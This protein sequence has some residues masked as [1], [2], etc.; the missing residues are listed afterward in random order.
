MPTPLLQ[1]IS[2]FEKLVGRSPNYTKLRVFGCLCYPRLKR[3]TTYKLE[4]KSKPCVSLGYSST[5]SAFKCLDPTTK[6]TLH[7]STCTICW[8]YISICFY[9]LKLA[10]NEEN[11]SK[12]APSLNSPSHIS[13]HTSS[14]IVHTENHSPLIQPN[15]HPSIYIPAIYQPHL[16]S[17]NFPEKSLLLSSTKYVSTKS[18]PKSCVSHCKCFQKFLSFRYDA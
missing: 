12:W 11:L 7:L 17:S 4:P 2:P 13:I 15:I 18:N 8:E 6:K 14:T 10:Q 16:H 9:C 5:Q 3:Y 1:L